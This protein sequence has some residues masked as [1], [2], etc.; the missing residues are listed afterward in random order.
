MEWIH[1]FSR[2]D[3]STCLI[4]VFKSFAKQFDFS[5]VVEFLFE[6]LSMDYVQSSAQAV[7]MTRMR[8]Q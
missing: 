5:S 7:K 3:L 1:D 8:R 2:G 4:R 6:F